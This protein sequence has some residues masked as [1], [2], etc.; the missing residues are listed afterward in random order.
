ME[1]YPPILL[2]P[3]R[4]SSGGSYIGCDSDSEDDFVIR[5]Y[6]QASAVWRSQFNGFRILRLVII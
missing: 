1:L 3:R 5:K 6:Y 2:N 4:Y